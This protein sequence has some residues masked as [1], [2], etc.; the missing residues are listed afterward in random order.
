MAG[1][2]TE[3]AFVAN[4][5]RVGFADIRVRHREP[6]GIEEMTRNPYLPAELV[7]LARQRVPAELRDRLGLRIVITARKPT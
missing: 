2:L 6:W 5:A 3:R 1:A 4:L 7:A